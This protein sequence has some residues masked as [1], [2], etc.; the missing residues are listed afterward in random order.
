MLSS[1]SYYSYA[2]LRWGGHWLRDCCSADCLAECCIAGS[3]QGQP[4]LAYGGGGAAPNDTVRTAWG[5][6]CEITQ[7][8]RGQRRNAAFSRNASVSIYARPL[9]FARPICAVQRALVSSQSLAAGSTL[10][11]KA[12]WT[13]ES[14]CT[15]LYTLAL[16]LC[17]AAA[18]AR[19]R[20]AS[21]QAG[22]ATRNTAPGRLY[23]DAVVAGLFK[24]HQPHRRR[25]GCTRL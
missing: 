23:K 21:S 7:R 14:I 6:D 4:L 5:R 1:Y 3:M 13:A 19:C 25:D 12:R 10:T 20:G 2:Y 11:T 16:A 24:E 17:L 22:A 15:A 18:Q 9:I 8:A